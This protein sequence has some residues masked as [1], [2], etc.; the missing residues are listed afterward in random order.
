MLFSVF[1]ANMATVANVYTGGNDFTTFDINI[2]GIVDNGWMWT[3]GTPFNYINW[4]AGDLY[5]IF[6]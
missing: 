5:F 4:N 2:A 6:F 1:L 3:D